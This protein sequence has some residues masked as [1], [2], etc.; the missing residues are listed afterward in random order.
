MSQG[1]KEADSQ[2]GPP[3]EKEKGPSL[4]DLIRQW[5]VIVAVMA[6]MVSLWFSFSDYQQKKSQLNRQ[7]VVQ[8]NSDAI[9]AGFIRDPHNTINLMQM[10]YP[11]H[12]FCASLGIFAAHSS[13][14]EVA[15]LR[16]QEVEGRTNLPLIHEALDEEM[17][18]IAGAQ[19]AQ[20]ALDVRKL[21]ISLGEDCAAVDAKPG[22]WAQW[23]G[24]A[25]CARAVEAYMENQCVVA[26]ERRQRLVEEE[27][28]KKANIETAA[29]LA[30][31]SVENLVIQSIE[32]CID[33]GEAE[34][35]APDYSI[36]MEPCQ[37][38]PR[39][40][41]QYRDPKDKDGVNAILAELRSLGWPNVGAEL[42]EGNAVRGD[43]RYYYAD[44]QPCALALSAITSKLMEQQQG[45]IQTFPHFSLEERFKDLPQGRI[46]LWFPVF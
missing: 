45:I 43:V 41:A 18:R 7:A 14:L 21:E 3:P 38:P 22:F 35:P 11:R 31:V 24:H 28:I 25:E 17:S 20:T 32:N 9:K 26:K 37:E 33:C 2:D 8:A 6:A 5:Q 16:D 39:I 23:L 12:A 30:K 27:E 15:I 46:E 34:P 1:G 40:Y 4:F 36:L 10:S 42:V 44:Q 29:E 19:F 13:T